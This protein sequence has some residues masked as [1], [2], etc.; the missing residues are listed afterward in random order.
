MTNDLFT[1]WSAFWASAMTVIPR[2]AAALLVLFLGWIL[3]ALVRRVTV[4]VLRRAKFDVLAERAGI[5]GFLVQ[6]GVPFT[7]A[8]LVAWFIYW[9]LILSAI[10]LALSIAG[11]GIADA[12]MQRILLY[13]PK[14]IVAVLVVAFGAL[15]ARFVRGALAAYLN[16]AGVEGARAISTIAQWA[17]LIF[18]GTIALEQLEIGG[19]TLTD[20]FKMAFGALCLAFGLAFGLGGRRWAQSL[21]EK[22]W[23][24]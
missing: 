14:V 20:A 10:S 21:L 24:P 9:L 13:I 22:V 2:I 8:S 6:G 15:F 16:N 17:I 11:V 4:R 18:V 19:Q 7:A 3:A 5:E 12:M 1:D 23:K